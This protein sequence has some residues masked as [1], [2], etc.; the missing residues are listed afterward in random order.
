MST[1]GSPHFHALY[2]EGYKLP[3]GQVLFPT[4]ALGAKPCHIKL[5]QKVPFCP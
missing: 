3:E 5:G 2:R 1:A 4:Q